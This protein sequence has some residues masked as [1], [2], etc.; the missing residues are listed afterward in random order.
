MKQVL[1]IILVI[2]LLS[3][4][5]FYIKYLR[6]ENNRLEGLEEGYRGQISEFTQRAVEFEKISQKREKEIQVLNKRQKD[7]QNEL[8]KAKQDDNFKDWFDS[9][10]PLNIHGLFKENTNN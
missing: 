5:V 3:T 9:P 2:S 7:F 6:S 10:L 4:S 8:E 1:G